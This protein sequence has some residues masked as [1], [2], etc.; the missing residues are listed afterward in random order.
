MLTS[1]KTMKRS[2]AALVV[3]MLAAGIVAKA[4]EPEH[5]SGNPT[6]C[7]RQIREFLVGKMYFGARLEDTKQGPIVESIVPLSP[8][9]NA[10]MKRLDR[11]LIVNGQDCAKGGVRRFKELIAAARDGRIVVTVMRTGRLVQLQTRM[12]PLSGA[13]VDKIVARHLKLAHNLAPPT[14][15]TAGKAN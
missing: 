14:E 9:D 7:S 6:A 13:Q 8:A 4:E 5:C 1:V 2:L 15:Q 12:T 3:L 10:G 11:V